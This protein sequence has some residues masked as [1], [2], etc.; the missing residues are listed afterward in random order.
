MGKK[1]GAVDETA[2]KPL[3]EDHLDHTEFRRMPFLPPPPFQLYLMRHAH[4]GWAL[5][6]QTDFDRTLDEPGMEEAG[7]IAARAAEQG[8][9]PDIVLCSTARRCRQTADAFLPA[10][11]AR[12]PEITYID[13]LYNAPPRVYFE[14]LSR[15]DHFQSVMLLGHNPAMEEILETLAGSRATAQAI[16]TGYPTAGFAA[17]RHDGSAATGAGWAITAFLS[18]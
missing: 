12:R 16:P 10:F 11:G 7:L 18:S 6:G 3:R 15:Y 14:V 8:F 1:H 9:C 2:L 17:L 13:D 4:S 5:P